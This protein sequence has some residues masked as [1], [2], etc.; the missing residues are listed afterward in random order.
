LIF[1]LVLPHQFPALG[2]R[3]IHGATGFSFVLDFGFRRSLFL[4]CAQI[5]I[6]SL[7]LLCLTPVRAA[8][9]LLLSGAESYGLV[10]GLICFSSFSRWAVSICCW[11]TARV[12]C[13]CLSRTARFTGAISQSGALPCY[14]LPLADP[15]MLGTQPPVGLSGQDSFFSFLF[16]PSTAV[17]L[18]FSAQVCFMVGLLHLAQGLAGVKSPVEP[19]HSPVPSLLVNRARPA[20]CSASD[21]AST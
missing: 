13:S 3:W 10:A 18:D 14:G 8:E 21:T 2:F 19:L 1:P 16:D 6:F 5:W 4:A 9:A 15:R 7:E 11:A 17:V 12:S 20:N